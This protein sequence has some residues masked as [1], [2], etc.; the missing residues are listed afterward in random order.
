[1]SELKIKFR[2]ELDRF[3]DKN[4]GAKLARLDEKQRALNLIGFSASG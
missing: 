4:F 3:A 1:M 2:D